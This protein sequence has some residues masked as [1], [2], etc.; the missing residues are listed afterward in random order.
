VEKRRIGYSDGVIRIV[1]ILETGTI[2]RISKIIWTPSP[3]DNFLRIYLT[4]SDAN[5]PEVELDMPGD[6][7]I[8]ELNNFGEEPWLL[9]FYAEELN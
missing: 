8:A 6:A 4:T 7:R 5:A 9:G 1:G 3:T 2:P